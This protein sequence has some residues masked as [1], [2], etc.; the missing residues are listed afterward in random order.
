VARNRAALIAAQLE[1]SR[2]SAAE[3]DPQVKQDLSI[4]LKSD[5]DQVETW[6]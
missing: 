6:T 2:R 3:E 4:L 5:Q 1:L